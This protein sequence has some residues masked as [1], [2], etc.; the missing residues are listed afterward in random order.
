[1]RPCLLHS[2]QAPSHNIRLLQEPSAAAAACRYAAADSCRFLVAQL[3]LMGASEARAPRSQP[4][5]LPVQTGS[6]MHAC[7]YICMSARTRTKWGAWEQ[8]SSVRATSSGFHAP[9]GIVC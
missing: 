1:M 6:T 3:T 4:P 7:M 2:P 8:E 9:G 5:S